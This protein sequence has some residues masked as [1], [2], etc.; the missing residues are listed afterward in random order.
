VSIS[1]LGAALAGGAS[2]RF[3]SPK[4]L[5]SVGGRTVLSRVLGALGEVCPE[6][7]LI[8]N[9]P[10]IAAAAGRSLPD[11]VPGLGPLG[12]IATALR[13]A[14]SH[15]FVGALCLAADTP[16]V[17]AALL[18]ELLVDPAAVVVPES[19]GRR[20]CEPLCAY[21]PVGVLDEARRAL[22]AG[23]RAPHRL[24]DRLPRVRHVPL[25]TVR[26]IGDPDILFLN[27]NTPEDLERAE[28]IA[29]GA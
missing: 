9:D 1:V 19:T 2:T 16:F 15:G 12:G 27:L 20:S 22:D 18:R 13:H 3:G 10:R 23:E 17:G 29:A 26:R 25:E 21:W 7:V 5:A 14:R 24:L 8:A 28:R 4:P 6:V 11:D